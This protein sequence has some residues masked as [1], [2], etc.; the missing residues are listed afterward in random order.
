[1]RAVVAQPLHGGHERVGVAGRDQ[2]GA[3][4][5][6]LRQRGD[7]VAGDRRAAGD[8]LEHRQPEALVAGRAH[9]AAGAAIE[10]GQVALVHE[11][12]E[13]D[14]RAGGLRAP[15][16]RR[17]RR[18][19]APGEHKPLG[20]IAGACPAPEGVD[21]ATDV[22]AR[23]GVGETADE[24][25]VRRRDQVARSA[26]GEARV[27]A[28]GH[29]V[30]P[31]YGHAE[32]VDH[33]GGRRVRRAENAPRPPRGDIEQPVHGASAQVA[34]G[35]QQRHHVVHRHHQRHAR[36]QRRAVDRQRVGDV[37]PCAPQ[38]DRQQHLLG[39]VGRA[40]R[41]GRAAH[42]PR[43][44]A[45]RGQRRRRARGPQHDHLPAAL[46]RDRGQRAQ[47]PLRVAA[48]P[49]RPQERDVERPPVEDRSQLPTA[50]R[51]TAS[52]RSAYGPGAKHRRARSCAAA[53]TRARSA[54]SSR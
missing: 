10:T 24:E 52:T 13:H 50:S 25:H 36:P 40:Q 27:H 19:G 20:P 2:V 32:A 17:C 46:G 23:I 39:Q 22:L 41:H 28:L 53:P 4:A 3:R 51:S 48:D 18:A 15:P 42:E 44:R 31:L 6:H 21:E 33:V 30:D 11:V 49:L 1:M 43:A 16:Q 12:R 29:H 35:P 37:G 8:G 54:G 5:A 14:R 47:Q 45:R 38:V 26:G 34:L 7:G 9:E